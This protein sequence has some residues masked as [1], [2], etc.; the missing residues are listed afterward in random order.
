MATKLGTSYA[1]GAR[2]EGNIHNS[3]SATYRN[4]FALATEGGGTDALLLA[5]VREGNT[6]SAV[7]MQADGNLSATNFTLSAL[8]ADGTTETLSAAQ[9]GPNATKKELV[10]NIATAKRVPFTQPADILLTPSAN[11]PSTGSI[12]TNVVTQKRG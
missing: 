4:D 6:L 12:V 1:T 11:L 2:P 10:F 7:T 5:K 8:F 9:A 3:G